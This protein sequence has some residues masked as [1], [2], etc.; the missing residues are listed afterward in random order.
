MEAVSSDD[1]ARRAS[2][3]RGGGHVHDWAPHPV[4]PG[5]R[6]CLSC[7]AVGG[8]GTRGCC[9]H[10][11]VARDSACSVV[12]HVVRVGDQ[13]LAFCDVHRARLH[14][15][16]VAL[17]VEAAARPPPPAVEPVARYDG[18]LKRCCT[19]RQSR[20]RDQF[21]KNAA[22]P[23][24]LGPRCRACNAASARRWREAHPE[25]Y[26]AM[27]ARKREAEAKA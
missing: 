5:V 4:E 11:F 19:C 25:R 15:E 6:V 21:P 18:P 3:A 7:R 26:A 14:R 17:Q 27:K 2:C 8:K 13:L 22:R 9:V 1:Q 23:D 12:R 24:G 20:P 16:I 10:L